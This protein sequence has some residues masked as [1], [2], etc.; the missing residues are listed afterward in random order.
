[1]QDAEKKTE[2]S[3]RL[4]TRRDWANVL[5]GAIIAAV[6]LILRNL[7]TVW[8]ALGDVYKVISPFLGGIVLAYFLNLLLV[9]IENHVMKW[10]KKPSRRHGWSVFVTIL[11]ILLVLA[12]LIYMLIPQLID[13]FSMLVSNMSSY[14]EQAYT[15]IVNLVDKL[16]I[17]S[18][19]VS[20]ILDSWD[21]MMS[22]ISSKLSDLLPSILN[23]SKQVGG[24]IVNFFIAFVISIY[25]LAD[26]DNIMRRVKTT[27]RA[28]LPD[29]SYTTLAVYARKSHK[30]FGGFLVGKAIDSL[31][32]GLITLAFL[33][34]FK[35]PYSG[36]IAFVIGL[37]N[38]VPTIGP[39]IGTIPCAFI[40]L[41]IDPLKALWFVIFIIILQQFD[42]NYLGP[43]ILSNSVGISP[44]WIFISVLFCG[45]IWGLFGALIG[46][47]LFSV[48]LDIFK[49]IVYGRLKKKEELKAQT[50][51]NIGGDESA[52][53]QETDAK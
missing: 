53:N 19:K 45:K 37:T 49:Q 32:I 52:G 4:L 11:V 31:I 6:Y 7:G 9:P 39:L 27:F 26:R 44:L 20:N 43:K 18:D 21:Q 17:N 22:T 2:K 46:V 24:S 33:L 29:K 28:F 25:V 35:Y 42:G 1:M 23:Y 5:V 8:S 14:I 51:E 34:I 47:P 12:A 38:M 15:A 50:E 13:S 30:A 41:L 16:G 40:L 36:L 3:K 10:I 48:L